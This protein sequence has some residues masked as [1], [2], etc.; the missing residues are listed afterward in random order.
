MIMRSVLCLTGAIIAASLNAAAVAQEI[1]W[2]KVDETLGRKAAV[3]GDV[4]RYGCH[5]WANDD[6]IK[7][8]KGLRAALN[9]SAVA[10]Q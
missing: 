3:S 6:A 10:L 8:A 5:F 4:H 2:Q 7:L 1:D 9:K